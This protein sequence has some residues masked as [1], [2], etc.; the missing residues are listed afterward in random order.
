MW[1]GVTRKFLEFLNPRRTPRSSIAWCNL[2][3]HIMFCFGAF[4]HHYI[5]NSREHD[6]T[7]WLRLCSC[8]LVYKW[9]A[10]KRGNVFETYRSCQVSWNHPANE[11]VKQ[12]WR[13]KKKKK[14]FTFLFQHNEHQQSKAVMLITFISSQMCVCYAIYGRTVL[15]VP[16]C[17]QVPC[18]P[19]C[20]SFQGRCWCKCWCGWAS[21]LQMDPAGTH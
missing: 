4:L 1:T 5:L 18:P 8:V 17:S 11:V 7:F 10:A 2:S 15:K 13:D 6:D 12:K 19:R 14:S 21:R 3:K 20:Q 16:R 9:E